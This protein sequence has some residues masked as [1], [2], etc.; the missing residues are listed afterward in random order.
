[1]RK[2]NYRG[3]RLLAGLMLFA[4]V[5]SAVAD[6]NVAT[7][8]AADNKLN[9]SD[10]N[11]ITQNLENSNITDESNASEEK[12][13]SGEAP[14]LKEDYQEDSLTETTP[15][16]NP[17]PEKIPEE[18]PDKS[19]EITEENKDLEVKKDSEEAKDEDS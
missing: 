1:M 3:K 12:N 8:F 6:C 18:N 4:M 5:S 17:N 16:S 15:N 13:I 9:I 14:A 11:N 10:Q 2:K 7:A 19:P